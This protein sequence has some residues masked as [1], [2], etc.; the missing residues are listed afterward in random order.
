MWDSKPK[1]RGHDCRGRTHGN[2][3]VG[4]GLCHLGVRPSARERVRGRRLARRCL[5]ASRSG[6]VD[7]V[8]E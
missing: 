8:D 5:V 2:P 3:K 6:T 4:A 1:K 7:D